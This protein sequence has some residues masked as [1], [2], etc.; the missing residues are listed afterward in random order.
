MLVK[1]LPQYMSDFRG[2]CIEAEEWANTAPKQYHYLQVYLAL[3]L[4]AR[5]M[6]IDSTDF[7]LVGYPS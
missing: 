3:S 2:L 5:D 4:K 1:I 7:L 6:S